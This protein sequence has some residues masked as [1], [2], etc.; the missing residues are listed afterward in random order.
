M[1]AAATRI[2][3]SASTANTGG[4]AELTAL[5]AA[6][7]GRYTWWIGGI[8]L[9][10][11]AAIA[12]LGAPTAMA[13]AIIMTAAVGLVGLP[14]GAYD[15]EVGRRLLASR[16]GAWWWVCF[17]GAYLL[18]T[19]AAAA[20]WAFAPEIGLALLL[21]GGAVHWG[22]DDLEIG[23]RRGRGLRLW[24]GA[25]R[26]AV[27][28]AA[29]MLLASGEVAVIFSALLN[30]RD[31]TP[32]FVVFSGALWLAAALPGLVVGAVLSFR[33][34][35]AAGVRS[36]LEP[37]VL[38]V[39]FGL[40][41]AVLGFTVYFCF[42]H[43]VRHSM[44]SAFSASPPDASRRS[45]AA[46][47]LRAIAFPTILTWAL[48]AVA[49]AALSRSA[50]TGSLDSLYGL[51]FIGLFALTVPHVLLEI[52][53]HRVASVDSMACRSASL[54]GPTKHGKRVPPSGLEPETR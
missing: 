42:W 21:L 16:L 45:I 51:V 38:L 1:P 12:L 32:G 29:P 46:D 53:E 3:S 47:Y 2:G 18:L 37:L 40:A 7:V 41:P 23:A 28:V 6:A 11:A 4:H 19:V 27:P 35:R 15:L 44:R 14:H 17:G 52:L 54:D 30:G 48:A 49:W 20:L 36:V 31:V 26:G 33:T 8:T 25:S 5:Q 39:W 50:G 10:A 24:L 9:T 34:N 22:L 43:S 13:S